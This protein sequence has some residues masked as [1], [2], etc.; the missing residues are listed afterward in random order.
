[1]NPAEYRSEVF[2]HG[3]TATSI[4]EICGLIA[5]AIEGRPETERIGLALEGVQMLARNLATNLFALSEQR[6]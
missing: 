3:A 6:G 5:D 4:A 2:G 1:M